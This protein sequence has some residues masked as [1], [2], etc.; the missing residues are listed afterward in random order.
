MLRFTSFGSVESPSIKASRYVSSL[1]MLIYF[2]LLCAS[3]N[4][5]NKDDNNDKYIVRVGVG[6]L[7]CA[8][9]R[10]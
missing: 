3:L 7:C 4:D 9:R 8:G 6:V 1:D 5:S 10:L 2:V